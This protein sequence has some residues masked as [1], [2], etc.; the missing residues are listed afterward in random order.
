ML[1]CCVCH[2]L[3]FG[4][5]FLPAIPAT[6]ISCCSLFLFIVLLYISF[7]TY[8]FI[9]KDLGICG[10]NN[11]NWIKR[12]LGPICLDLSKP[13]CRRTVF[14]SRSVFCCKSFSLAFLS[15]GLSCSLVFLVGF[16]ALLFIGLSSIWAFEFCF[17]LGFLP[18][19][20]LSM[21]LQKLTSIIV[22]GCNITLWKRG[23]GVIAKSKM[24]KFNIT[25]CLE[26]GRWHLL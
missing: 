20:L 25:L 13:F 26:E 21:N 23:F 18:H 22:Y 19:S 8:P 9:Q 11:I 17:L 14:C 7:H 1:S 4:F 3:W 5:S 24:V 2:F 6:Y 12:V 10:P 16:W 15:L